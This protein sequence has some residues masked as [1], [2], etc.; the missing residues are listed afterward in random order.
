M[1][2]ARG[3][4]VGGCSIGVI[5]PST[6]ECVFPVAPN[7]ATRYFASRVYSRYGNDAARTTSSQLQR[8]SSS[9]GAAE[10]RLTRFV[11][12]TTIVVQ[13]PNRASASR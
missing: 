13:H 5:A 6:P 1:L 9:P 4:V 7:H 8:V 10:S 11:P 3:F 2:P 12:W